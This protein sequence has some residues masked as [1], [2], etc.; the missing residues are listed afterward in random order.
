MTTIKQIN[1]VLSFTP[2]NPH[3]E[4]L[5]IEKFKQLS[6]LHQLEDKQVQ[7]MIL[8]IKALARIVIDFQIGSEPVKEIEPDVNHEQFK[9]AA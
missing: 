6:G 4:E 1:P 9:Q 8:S 5:T 2:L 3:N 7:D